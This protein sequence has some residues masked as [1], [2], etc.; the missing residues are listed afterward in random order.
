MQVS[1]CLWC[2][3]DL[4]QQTV[5]TKKVSKF[6]IFDSKKC[7]LKDRELHPDQKIYILQITVLGFYY[8]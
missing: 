4:Q 3:F 6:A 5:P 2:R 1:Q 8:E 7:W